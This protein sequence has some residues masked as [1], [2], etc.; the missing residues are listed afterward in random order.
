MYTTTHTSVLTCDVRSHT[1]TPCHD[2]KPGWYQ[3]WAWNFTARIQM[4]AYLVPVASTKHVL[5][6][7]KTEYSTVIATYKHI[8]VDP[9]PIC[10]RD[11]YRY[12]AARTLYL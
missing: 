12:F 3:S 1:R 9:N 4:H 6:H 11:I 5:V 8:T 7:T 2:S 10:V